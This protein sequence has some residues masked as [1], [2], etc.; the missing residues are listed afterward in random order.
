MTT[1]SRKGTLDPLAEPDE[2]IAREGQEHELA[3]IEDLRD[4]RCVSR[5]DGPTP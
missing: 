3:T 4:T 5:V 1:S 2:I